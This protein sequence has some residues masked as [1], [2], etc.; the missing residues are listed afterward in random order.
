MSHLDLQIRRVQRRLWLNR[1]MHAFFFCLSILAGLFA[2]FVLVQRLYDLAWP[3]MW[4]GV[5][6]G[7]AALFGSLVWM[8]MTREDVHVAATALDQAAGLRER[9]RSAQYC[10][11][12]DDPFARAV[13][14]DAEQVSTSLSVRN[15]IRLRFPQPLSWASFSVVAAALM[16]LVTPGLLKPTE[17]GE[18]VDELE[19]TR[20]TKAVV[21]KKLQEIQRL[22]E[23]NP[24]LADFADDI[25]DL[26]K[27]AGGMLKPG[28]VRHEAVKKIDRLAD[29]VRKKQGDLKY[30]ANQEMRRMFRRLQAPKSGIEATQKLARKLQQGD[31]KSAREEIAK[32]QEQLAT[33]KSESD[34]DLVQ[35]IG[36]DLEKLAKQ[37]EQLSIDKK[38][39]QKLAEAGL[40]KEDLERMLQTLGKKDLEK[41][42]K[43]LEKQGLNQKQ[44]S[45]TIQKL[46]QQ[47]QGAAQAQQMAKGLQK[48]ATACKSGQVGDGAAAGLAQAAG[49]LSEAE[50]LEVEMA[51]IEATLAQLNSARNS[52]DSSCSQCKGTGKRGGKP[53]SACRG[54]GSRPGSGG[55]M[56][57]LGK[58]R[59][60]LAPE[61]Q[62]GMGFKIE[63]AKV[64]TG[65]GAIIGQFL[66]D[67]EQ[68]KGDVQSAL[69]E[70]VAASEHDASDRIGRNRIPRQY[71][72]AVKEYFANVR[73]LVKDP[74]SPNDD[75]GSPKSDPEGD[76]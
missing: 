71:Q 47:Q 65:K 18:G 54:S 73:R 61:Q 69:S 22:A 74:K 26:D 46:Q 36:K 60:G 2:A 43:A 37:L 9:L 8:W 68:V 23:E 64:H 3:V 17:A 38:L 21:K 66:V 70:V 40:K 41:I 33:L 32:L 76:E 1:W 44:I 72:K 35:K 25:R 63:R 4:S 55:G 56:G 14:A 39:A 34:K 31:F 62:A 59:G 6:L 67:G 53:C 42:R 48:A 13:V 10:L 28:D 7:I 30:K 51:Q 16:F 12:K 20:Q 27:Q 49:Q 52:L 57:G 45:K 58:G 15:H 5:G 29:A 24:A 19:L 75:P 11:N 50:A